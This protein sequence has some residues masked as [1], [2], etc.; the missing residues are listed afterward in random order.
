MRTLLTTALLAVTTASLAAQNLTLDK[1]GGGLGT[2]S[3]FP[4]QGLPNEQFFLIT[5]VF[6][7]PTFE[8]NLGITLDLSLELVWCTFAFPGWTG[9]MSATGATTP[10][11]TFPDWPWLGDLV[12]SFQ[13]IAG[14]NPWR[15]SNL[16]RLTPQFPGTWREPLNQPTAPIAGG[17]TAAAPNNE[18]LF[19]GGS[20][21]VAQRYKSRTEE[22]EAAGV[23][24][25]VGTFSQTTGLPDGRV[26]F[27]G[28][29][30]PLTG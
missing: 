26:L 7:Q 22:W 2:L 15:T 12:W 20:G 5:N 10:S 17:G 18:L 9:N 6:E 16:V 1:V 14:D 27:T 13:A 23:T 30:D 29:L 25:G 4:M 21:P 28:G 11:V 8:P 3:T 24:F 19:V